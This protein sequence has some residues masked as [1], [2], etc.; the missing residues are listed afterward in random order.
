MDLTLRDEINRVRANWYENDSYC[1]FRIQ[2]DIFD[3]ERT[4]IYISWKI[5][6]YTK[7]DNLELL[8]DHS[9]S[10]IVPRYERDAINS[11]ENKMAV[12]FLTAYREYC[13]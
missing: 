7:K 8:E 5:F 6:R 9:E 12:G 10:F 4:Q 3:S 2:R 13:C 1:E 11:F